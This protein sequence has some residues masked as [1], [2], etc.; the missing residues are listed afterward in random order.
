MKVLS[1]GRHRGPDCRSLTATMPPRSTGRLE[2]CRTQWE[3][4]ASFH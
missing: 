2:P 1:K 3:H 4:S